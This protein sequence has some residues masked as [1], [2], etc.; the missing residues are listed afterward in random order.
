MYS[1]G[2]NGYRQIDD[3]PSASYATPK[4]VAAPTG[5]QWASVSAGYGHTLALCTDGTLYTWGTNHYGQLGNGIAST[6]GRLQIPAPGSGQMWTQVAAGY[7]FSLALCSDGSLYAWGNNDQ[8]QLGDGTTQQRLTPVR[9]TP[10]NGHRWTRITA[11]F[12]NSAALCSD[13]LLYM[14]GANH[15]GQLGDGT[16]TQ[17]SASVPIPPP[18]GTSWQQVSTG[19]QHTIA[20]CSNGFLYVWGSNYYGELG[21]GTNISRTT[22]S[23]VAPPTGLSWTQ[24]A[25]SSF[26]SLA[27]ASNGQMYSTGYNFSGEL[28]NGTTTS[29]NRFVPIGSP[30]ST[31]GFTETG[32]SQLS[33]SLHPNP[34][35]E[36]LQVE[37]TVQR[38][39]TA[40]ATLY[41]ALGQRVQHQLVSLRPGKNKTTISGLSELTTGVYFL[42]I[43]A[44]HAQ[45]IVQVVH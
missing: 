11:G 44:E 43:T 33:V 32:S 8:G 35:K 30:L 21:N 37:I 34:F 38:A 45:Q 23:P 41:T 16:T 39:C 10:P 19:Y 26:H 2:S 9:I 1:W 6:L 4:L 18:A 7:N 31:S 29:S 15:Q 28:G 13:G 17:Q 12:W 22:P 36:L 5:K 42:S 25:C 14:W 27:L 40:S 20:V 24:V 3:G